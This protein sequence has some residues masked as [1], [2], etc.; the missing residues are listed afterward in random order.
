MPDRPWVMTHDWPITINVERLMNDPEHREAL[1]SDFNGGDRDKA[2][3]YSIIEFTHDS[4]N[5]APRHRRKSYADA[6]M[7][8][9]ERVPHL[10]PNRALSIKC[11][12]SGS[13]EFYDD[14]VD[15]L[16]ELFT[17]A[18]DTMKP[19]KNTKWSRADRNTVFRPKLFL[20][21]D[22]P[23]TLHMILNGISTEHEWIV[24]MLGCSLTPD[25]ASPAIF[26]EK[27]L[28]DSRKKIVD[29]FCT[30][31]STHPKVIVLAFMAT[32]FTVREFYR[33]ADSS[34]NPEFLIKA[35]FERDP[36]RKRGSD[37]IEKEGVDYVL[38]ENESIE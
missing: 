20:H 30:F 34:M 21:V 14:E 38:Y 19:H 15:A 9:A 22:R 11:Q 1:I 25:I 3:A 26:T 13:F 37:Y 5:R 8:I 27:N 18:G 24:N 36:L 28:M 31:A 12:G 16:R 4:D 33:I 10:C 35:V 17:Q 7:L 29:M 2:F 6:I 23:S 32:T